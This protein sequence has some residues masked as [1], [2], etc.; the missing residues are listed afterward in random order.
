IDPAHEG[1][2]RLLLF[3]RHLGIERHHRALHV[4]LGKVAAEIPGQPDLRAVHLHIADVAFGDLDR[5]VELAVVSPLRAGVEVARAKKMAGAGFDVIRL[6]APGLVLSSLERWQADG[7]GADDDGNC[8]FPALHAN[9]PR[10]CFG[11][12]VNGFFRSYVRRT[13]LTPR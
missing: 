2:D 8:K 7:H 5:I 4:A 13:E 11:F 3:R 10:S 12:S 9:L 1:L 6:D